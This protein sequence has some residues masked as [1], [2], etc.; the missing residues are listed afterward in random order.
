[1]HENGK[2]MF[3]KYGLPLLLE[4]AGLKVLAAAHES[5]DGARMDCAG[6]G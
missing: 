2:R 4:D 3:I 5:I 6:G 1:M